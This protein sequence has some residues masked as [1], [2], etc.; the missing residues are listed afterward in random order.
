MK[1]SWAH[2]GTALSLT[3]LSGCMST[4][5]L[6]TTAGIGTTTGNA[7]VVANSFADIPIAPSDFIDVQRS[8]LLNTGEQWIGRAVLKS[9]QALSE[10]FGYYQANMSQYGWIAITSVQANISVLTFEKGQR[11]A[12]IHIEPSTLLG[13]VISITVTPRETS[14]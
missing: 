5:L 9:S 1:S 12:T 14:R 4:G 3:I 7:P 8:L 11:V 10:A 13:S 2:L 6:T